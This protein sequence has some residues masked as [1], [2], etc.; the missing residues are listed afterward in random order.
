MVGMELGAE[1]ST[2]GHMV[3]ISYDDG[4]VVRLVVEPDSIVLRMHL[5]VADDGDDA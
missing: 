4:H 1:I 2:D 3:T 5:G